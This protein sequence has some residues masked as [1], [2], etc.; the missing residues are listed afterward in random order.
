MP[1]GDSDRY[2]HCT[3][4]EHLYSFVCISDLLTGILWNR[5]HAVGGSDEAL[6]VVVDRDLLFLQ[7][8]GFVF[9][10]L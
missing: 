8:H 9:F 3:Q 5:V 6:T 10:F 1:Y 7:L 4:Y 2:G